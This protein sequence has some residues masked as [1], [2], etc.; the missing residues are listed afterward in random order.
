MAPAGVEQERSNSA[1]MY[2]SVQNKFVDF[3]ARFEGTVSFMYL[4]V[5]GL[6]NFKIADKELLDSVI[7]T[8]AEKAKLQ[9]RGDAYYRPKAVKPQ[10]N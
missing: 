6:V 4:D 8:L 7:Q 2:Q 3:T 10:P 5:K 9:Q 1:Q